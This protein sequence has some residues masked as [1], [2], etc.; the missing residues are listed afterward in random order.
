MDSI[1]YSDLWYG[2][3]VKMQGGWSLER[4]DPGSI[5]EG[6]FNWAASKDPAGGT[7]GKQNSVYISG[8]DKLPLKAD[9]LSRPSD[10]TLLVYFNKPLHQVTIVKENFS[11]LP[12]SGQI[13]INIDPGFRQITLTFSGKFIPG[14]TYKLSISNVQDCSG[15]SISSS[16]APLSFSLAELPPPPPE[17]TDTARVFITELFAD[18]SP[19]VGL[20]LVEFIEIYNPG[21]DSLDLEGWSISDPQTKGLLKKSS[22]PPQQYLILCPAA[23]TAQYKGFGRTLG[24]APWP[25]LNNTSDQIVLKSFKNRIVD[26]IAYSDLWYGD[27]VKKQGGWSLEKIDLSDNKCPA[28]Y[29]WIASINSSGGT[30]GQRNSRDRP[31]YLNEPLKIDSMKLL[32]ENRLD[33]FLNRIPDTTFLNASSFRINN[34]IGKAKFARISS[35]YNQ[36][37][38]EFGFKFQEGIEYMVLADSLF[39]CSGILTLAPDNQVSFSI[40]SIP[41]IDYP[42][43][44][45][46]IFADPSP[47][48]G[49]PEAEFIELFNPT[50]KAINIK[51]LGFGDQDNTYQF[52]SGEIA[53]G[54]YLILCAA[55]DSSGFKAFGMVKGL[56][57]WPDLNNESDILILRNN[58]G[59]EIQRVGYE[60]KWYKDAEKRK[61]GHSLELID[62]SSICISSQNWTASLDS[63]GGTPGRKNSVYQVNTPSGPLKLTE[64][65]IIDSISLSLG[66]NRNIDSLKAASS[67]NFTLNNGIGNPQYSKPQ[68]PDFDKVILKFKEPLARGHTYRITVNNL[69]DCRNN[70]IT[71]EF[72]SMEFILTQK[73]GKNDILLTEILF[74]PRPEG[75]DFVEIYNNTDHALDLKELALARIIKDTINSLQPIVNKQ[76]LLEPRHYLAL[77]P[78]PDHIKKEYHTKDPASLLKMSSFPALSAE[79]GTSGLISDGQR[80]DQLSYNEKMHFPL[81]KNLKGV[82]LE[83][84]NLNRPANDPGNLRSATSA[85]GYA[86]PGYKNSQYSE[87]LPGQ[88]EFSLAS[89]TF[90][91][92]NDGFEDILQMNYRLSN[93][94]RIAN[95]SIFNDQGVL[96]KKLLKNYT[97]NAEG[98]FIWDG[99]NEQSQLATSGI[100]L[101]YAEILDTSG[102]IRKYRRTCVLAVK[103]N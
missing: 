62:P 4:I 96:I 58:K 60:T 54:S 34:G 42:I 29:N 7:P 17:K 20:P 100:Y 1:A 56:P 25:S 99:F 19:E 82:S 49:L 46:E 9:S 94:G 66:F 3:A 6:L 103:F 21:K 45:N 35:A 77:S 18:P 40:P 92:D 97:L 68:S 98:S 2:D 80:I 55:K 63:S 86:T 13:K 72:N 73:I 83:R 11:L 39:S 74:N 48:K 71:V 57:L 101:I 47:V 50:E 41:E 78:E 14:K 27:A 91:P 95:V 61:G 64:A 52:T 79:S 23:D 12:A 81:I 102:L 89:K 84:S 24:I 87:D 26:S 67:D 51:G 10:S 28:F 32:S 53:P 69:T 5:C 90:S 44:I 37:T 8:Y 31:G 85:S 16:S 30:P 43:L 15:S 38:L 65:V 70:L 36:I 76:Y 22:L 33:L 75:T 88:E 93:A 59:R